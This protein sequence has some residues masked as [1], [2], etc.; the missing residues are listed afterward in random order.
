MNSTNITIAY[1]EQPNDADF[2]GGHIA[3]K[4]LCDSLPFLGSCIQRKYSSRSWNDYAEGTRSYSFCGSRSCIAAWINGNL[5]GFQ[6]IQYSLAKKCIVTCDDPRHFFQIFYAH[7]IQ[8]I[9]WP[10]CLIL[11]LACIERV[12]SRCSSKS[13]TLHFRWPLSMQSGFDILWPTLSQFCLSST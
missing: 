7:T 3:D 11:A 10:S 8:N 5:K 4:I 6:F 9:T 12:S 1:R 2:I 13:T